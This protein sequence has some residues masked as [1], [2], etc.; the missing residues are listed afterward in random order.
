MRIMHPDI[1]LANT[2]KLCIRDLDLHVGIGLHWV[3]GEQ[4]RV[5]VDFGADTNNISVR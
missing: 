3:R 1:L 5:T 2:G 4:G